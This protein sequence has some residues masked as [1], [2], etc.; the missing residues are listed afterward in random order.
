MY[1]V[2]AILHDDRLDGA[3]CGRSQ[4]AQTCRFVGVGI[5]HQRLFAI[6][7]KNIWCE[8][9]ALRVAKASIQVNDNTHMHIPCLLRVSGKLF[10]SSW[11]TY[12]Y[13]E[14]IFL[15]RDGGFLTRIPFFGLLGLSRAV[16]TR[17]ADAVR[18]LA[19][20]PLSDRVTRSDTNRK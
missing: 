20:T 15:K 10:A 16:V 12:L 18:L 5:I 4:D 19:R 7:F 13:G 8:K 2:E 17:E 6:Q 1:L 9:S 11:L 14:T 3:S